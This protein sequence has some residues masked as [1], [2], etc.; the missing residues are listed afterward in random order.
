MVQNVAAAA[1]IEQRRTMTYEEWL[2]WADGNVQ[3]EWVKGEGTKFVPGDPAHARASRLLLQLL[4]FFVDLFDL[5]EVFHA[6]LEVRLEAIPASR[7]P[8]VLFL[9]REH[10]HRVG[11]KRIEGPVDLA[12]EI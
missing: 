5:G 11:P 2:T 7:E 6:P 8:D 1:A 4:A 12:I 10:L 9:A 3:A